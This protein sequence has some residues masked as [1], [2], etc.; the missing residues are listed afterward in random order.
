MIDLVLNE[1]TGQ[2]EFGESSSRHVVD[3]LTFCKGWCKPHPYVGACV[4]DMTND[5]TT[6]LGVSRQV[7]KNELKQDGAT[8][9]KLLLT[10]V[11]DTVNI[12]IDVTYK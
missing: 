6:G 10:P 2:V 1:N 5:H 9:N 11:N 8:V 7:I 3:L 12:E 4:F